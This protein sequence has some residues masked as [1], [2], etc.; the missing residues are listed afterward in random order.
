MNFDRSLPP[1]PS[2]LSLAPRRA[3]PPVSLPVIHALCRSSAEPPRR[4]RRLPDASRGAL[5]DGEEEEE[6]GDDALGDCGCG[7]VGQMD[8]RGNLSTARDGAECQSW[9]DTVYAPES[10]PHAGLDENFCRNP[11]G[12]E[13]AWCFTARGGQSFDYCDVPLCGNCADVVTDVPCGRDRPC[14]TSA[15]GSPLFCDFQLGPDAGG[16]CVDCRA[17]EFMLM[18]ISINLESPDENENLGFLDYDDKCFL[19]CLEPC[20]AGSFCNAF[21]GTCDSCLELGI[22]HPSVCD[23]LFDKA[24]T[25]QECQER[26]P[27]VTCRQ[28]LDCFVEWDFD[29]DY[30][31]DFDG[32]L[33]LSNSTDVALSQDFDSENINDNINGNGTNN[34]NNEGLGSDENLTSSDNISL[35]SGINSISD[36]NWSSNCESIYL[37]GWRFST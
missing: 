34:S 18:S 16:Y 35:D 24:A 29:Y 25:V 14:G 17:G 11:V 19:S 15:E 33:A 20:E 10:Y 13:R 12:Y 7:N 26:C 37:L 9:T 31:Y 3:S 5:E 21:Y 8:Y 22:V 4:P 1:S 2:D 27:P 23:A 30:S 28:S 36:G 32:P 6:E